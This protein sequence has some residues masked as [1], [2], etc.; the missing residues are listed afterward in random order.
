M[1]FKRKQIGFRV[2]RSEKK[3]KATILSLRS[4]EGKR[5]LELLEY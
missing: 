1:V 3:R 5:N 4:R 2:Q